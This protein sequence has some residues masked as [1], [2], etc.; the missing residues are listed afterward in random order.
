MFFSIW[1]PDIA[2][3]RKTFNDT[4][5]FKDKCDLGIAGVRTGIKVKLQISSLDANL[6]ACVLWN[7]AGVC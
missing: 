1:E 5:F 4:M 3:Q 6:G 2:V 7:L